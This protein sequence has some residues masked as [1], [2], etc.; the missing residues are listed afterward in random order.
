MLHHD[1]LHL[2]DYRISLR[3]DL[4][5]SCIISHSSAILFLDNQR[6]RGHL[7]K[8]LGCMVATIESLDT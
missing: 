1:Y 6:G 8:Q 4:C 3:A 7:P 5:C 2:S